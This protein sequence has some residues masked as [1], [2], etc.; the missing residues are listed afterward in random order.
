V[1]VSENAPASQKRLT[2]SLKP[3]SM[4]A[5]ASLPKIP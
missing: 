2:K 3:E 1:K 4:K 5:S